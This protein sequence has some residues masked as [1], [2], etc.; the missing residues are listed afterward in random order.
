M[1]TKFQ[2]MS[3]IAAA[4]LLSQAGA[5][6]CFGQTVAHFTQPTL[7]RWEYPFSASPGNS[8]YAAIFSPLTASGFDPMFDNRDGQMTLGFNTAASITPGLG[9]N[10]YQVQSAVVRLTVESDS[11]FKYDPTPDPWQSWLLPDDPDHVPDTDLG[12]P[13]ELFG[14]EFRYGFTASTF[15][16]NTPF[17]PLG[18]I[19]KSLRTAYPT[20]FISGQ[21][22]DASNNVDAGFDPI[23][24]AVGT[25]SLAPGVSVPAG[26]VFTFTVNVGDPDVHRFIR[27]ALDAGMLDFS[28]ASIF[29]SDQQTTGTYPRFYTKENLVVI[30][31]LAGAAQ[32]DLAVN[33]L[34]QA[35]PAGDVNG[36]GAVNIDD[37]FMV[38]NAWGPC[39]CCAADVNGDQ[40]V[41]IDDLF[42]VINSWG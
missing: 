8:G 33:I 19:G 41:D 34:P 5:A 26:T 6:A 35:A 32:L 16:E 12:H 27:K 11:T 37:L 36:D 20:C 23:P 1:K 40:G 38:I 28:V 42:I 10:R 14:T 13:V 15:L 25:C 7:D 2:R 21:C 18:A 24:F 30:A 9:P 39:A 22:E 17:S 29:P 31:G 4:A 3:M